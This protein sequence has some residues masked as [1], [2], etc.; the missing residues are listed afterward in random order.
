MQTEILFF[1]GSYS[2]AAHLTEEDT[3]AV[4]LIKNNELMGWIDLQDELRPEAKGVVDHL[5]SKGIKTI[6]LSGDRFEKTKRL[7][8]LLGIEKV[9]AE[10]TPEQKL[11]TIAALTAEQPTI[12]VGDGI[13]DAPALAKATIG[14]SMSEASQ[15]AMQSAQVVLK[16]RRL[17]HMKIL[18]F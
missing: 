12:M 1:A 18:S 7:A 11:Q 2:I 8:D 9:I 13:N 10:Q 15:L 17:Q 6:I 3:H 14:I 5:R 16:H 4:Y